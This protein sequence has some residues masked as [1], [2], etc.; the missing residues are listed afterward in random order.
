MIRSRSRSLLATGVAIALAT[1][2]I[3]AAQAPRRFTWWRSDSVVKEIG[4]TPD[5]V[6]TIE[7]VFQR[8]RPEARQEFEELEA[9]EAKLS[10]LIQSDADEGAVVRQIDRVE[11]ARSALRKTRSLM[12]LRMRRVLTP[13]QRILLTD[14]ENRRSRD[15][16]R[17]NASPQR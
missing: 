8:M 9:Q 12:L 17:S 16:E 5:Q 3:W 1:S 10:S 15:R 11:T 7:A 2:A 6:E 4:L 14:I 13:E